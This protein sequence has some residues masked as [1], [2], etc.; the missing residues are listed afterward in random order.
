[1]AQNL[2]DTDS[3][4]QGVSKGSFNGGTKDI[5]T[6]VNLVQ[7]LKRENDQLKARLENKQEF[8]KQV[9]LEDKLKESE[10]M[11]SALKKEIRSVQRIQL[12]QG[13]AL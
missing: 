9:E 3:A 10:A 12:D 4:F 13:K 2:K 7:Q 8:Q 11:V 6:L 1:L 5:A